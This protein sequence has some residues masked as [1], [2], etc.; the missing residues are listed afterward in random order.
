MFIE[1]VLEL[2]RGLPALVLLA[3]PS[4]LV[5]DVTVF[6][7]IMINL[8]L[9]DKFVNTCIISICMIKYQLRCE[10]NHQFDGWF[11]NINEFERQQHKHLL[12]CP[13]CDSKKV[14]R[15]IMSPAVSKVRAKEK[16]KKDY[17]DQITEDTM[18]PA[19]SAR[20]L[21][22]KIR[23]HIVT[24]FDNVGN[25]FVKEYRRHEKGDRDDRFYGT[26]NKKQ[27]KEL[28]EEGINLFHVPDIKDDA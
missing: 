26:P 15:A 12:T 10:H 1:D 20:M 28:M 5:F 3:C 8:T 17:S 25:E 14:D 24:E 21:L 6:F 27:I 23:K 16:K 13:L 2:G 9:F 22:K 11:P 19:A 4:F 7:A 18:I